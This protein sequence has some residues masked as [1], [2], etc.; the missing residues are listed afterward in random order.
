MQTVG[1]PSIHLYFDAMGHCL[2]IKGTEEAEKSSTGMGHIL[3]PL[4]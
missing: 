2:F 1:N 3:T 4:K